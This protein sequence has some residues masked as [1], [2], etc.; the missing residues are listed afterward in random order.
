MTQLYE[1]IDRSVS[2]GEWINQVDPMGFQ[3]TVLELMTPT[4][5]RAD[6]LNPVCVGV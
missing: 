5:A 1:S 3:R 2:S 6:V 4:Q